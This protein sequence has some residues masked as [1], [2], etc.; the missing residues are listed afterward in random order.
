MATGTATLLVRPR[1]A[2][3]PRALEVELLAGEA[4]TITVDLAARGIVAGVVRDAADRP[5][6]RAEVRHG[7]YAGFLSTLAR[8]DADGRFVL[9]ALPLGDVDLQVEKKGEGKA[10]ATLRVTSG[11]QIEWNPTLE[12]GLVYRARIVDEVREPRAGWDVYA[13]AR[14]LEGTGRTLWSRSAK[15]G[16]DGRFEITGCPD[17]ELRLELRAPEYTPVPIAMHTARPSALEDTIVVAAADLPNSSVEGS[18]VDAHGHGVAGKVT[19]RQAGRAFAYEAFVDQASGRYEMT[20][21]VRGDYTV[22][23]TGSDHPTEVVARVALAASAHKDLGAWKLAE[24]GY[25]RV[26]VRGQAGVGEPVDELRITGPLD[27]APEAADGKSRPTSVHVAA[28]TSDPI[29]LRAGR[30]EVGVRGAAM[31]AEVHTVEIRAGETTPLA[32]DPQPGEVCTF[33]LDLAG[34]ITAPSIATLV[35]RDA[36]DR[37]VASWSTLRP[38]GGEWTTEQRLPTGQVRLTVRDATPSAARGADGLARLCGKLDVVVSAGG[39]RWRVDL[40]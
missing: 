16:S 24:P 30:Y 34:G 27:A 15:S 31:L 37:I 2:L 18:V 8:T 9:D 17:A 13:M 32:L 10:K 38:G 19:A 3:A 39:G 11:V 6:A 36:T 29:P 35:A 25:L 14:T 33:T 20:S 1:G 12:R 22:S 7:A 26:A 23:F 21:M 5:V 40:R 4:R 28:G